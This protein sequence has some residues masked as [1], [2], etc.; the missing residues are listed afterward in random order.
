MGRENYAYNTPK[1]SFFLNITDIVLNLLKGDKLLG[2]HG[3][4]VVWLPCHRVAERGTPSSS[5]DL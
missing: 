5:R 4:T 3:F 1:K 2:M